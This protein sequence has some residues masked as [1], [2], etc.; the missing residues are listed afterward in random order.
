MNADTISVHAHESLMKN[1]INSWQTRIQNRQQQ[2]VQMKRAEPGD[3][4][5]S[6]SAKPSIQ[7]LQGE[8]QLLRQKDRELLAQQARLEQQAV[9]QRKDAQA[10]EDT[11]NAEEN[12]L[13]AQVQKRLTPSRRAPSRGELLCCCRLPRDGVRRLYT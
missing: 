2:I 13:R 11:Y 8:L 4:A 6:A 1:Q 12:E 5:P 9:K 3:P 10:N 7:K